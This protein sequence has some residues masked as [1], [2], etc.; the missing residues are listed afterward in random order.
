MLATVSKMLENVRKEAAPPSEVTPP[1]AIMSFNQCDEQESEDSEELEESVE[2]DIESDRLVYHK[3]SQI[4]S[5][6]AQKEESEESEE[7]D[8]ESDRLVYHKKSQIASDIAQKEAFIRALPTCLLLTV[9]F[10]FPDNTRCF[11]PCS[12]KMRKW[13]ELNNLQFIDYDGPGCH[14]KNSGYFKCPDNL[15]Q[16]L[17]ALQNEGNNHFHGLVLEYLNLLYHT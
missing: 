2:Y 13:R 4:A 9:G 1:S 17:I 11:C 5:D 15:K 6:I 14:G 3:K 16:H 10:N 7:D 12:I 8:I